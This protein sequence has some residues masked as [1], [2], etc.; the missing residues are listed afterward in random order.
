MDVR[1][2]K[3]TDI[4]MGNEMNEM[5]VMNGMRETTRA[6]SVSVLVDQP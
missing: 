3:N 6:E 5:Y 1:K 4:E 2:C